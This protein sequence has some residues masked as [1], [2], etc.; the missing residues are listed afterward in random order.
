MDVFQ[1]ADRITELESVVQPVAHAETRDR[2]LWKRIK[3]DRYRR[4]QL[5][6]REVALNERLSRFHSNP[7]HNKWVSEWIHTKSK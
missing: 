1:R 3:A 7:N 6:L 5:G 4:K 2:K